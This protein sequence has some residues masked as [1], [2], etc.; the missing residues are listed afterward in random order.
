[1]IFDILLSGAS[2]G[3][4]WGLLALGFF[5]SFRILDFA[6]MTC[7]GSITLGGAITTMLIWKGVN[8]LIAMLIAFLLGALAGTVTGIL[9]T[10][11]KIPPILSGILTMTALYSV[12]IHIMS[13][14]TGVDGTANLSL[15]K[16]RDSTDFIALKN[17][18][19][20]STKNATLLLGFI[21][22]AAVIAILYWFF[23]TELGCSIRATGNNEK[24]CRAQGIST[25]LMKIL[26]LAIANGLIALSGSLLCQYQSFAD[27]KMGTGSIVIGLA[28]II[29][30]EAIFAKA[31]N[32]AM[33]M[34]GIIVGAVIYRIIVALVIYSGMPSDDLKLMTA[35]VVVIA[36]TITNFKGEI[37]NYVSKLRTSERRTDNE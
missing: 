6:D 17:I 25:D 12:N 15:L 14:A 7:E 30:G 36:L 22:I 37:K 32:F 2:Q 16:Y 33:K 8:V 3:L 9:H 24:M 10:K 1:M 11:L 23:G 31:K 19:G 26:G 27:V 20:I 5:I 29:I 34:T 4:V 21:I 28:S 18:L 13:F 35:A